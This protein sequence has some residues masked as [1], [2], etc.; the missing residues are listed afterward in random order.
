[1]EWPW[2]KW[3][4]LRAPDL[5]GQ[6]SRGAVALFAGLRVLPRTVISQGRF[7]AITLKCAQPSPQQF[8]ETVLNS[9]EHRA[10]A[11]WQA[12]LLFGY[13]SCE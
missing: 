10:Q 12:R 13:G 8:M 9:W 11:L 1:M 4:L 6:G 3:D 2:Q 5:G 7:L